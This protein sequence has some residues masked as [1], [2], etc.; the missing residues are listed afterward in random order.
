MP[1]RTTFT[2]C[3]STLPRIKKI[4]PPC[5]C[6]RTI[7]HRT[8]VVHRCK[9]VLRRLGCCGRHHNCTF[10]RVAIR[11][12]DA[13]YPRRLIRLGVIHARSTPLRTSIALGSFTTT[14]HFRLSAGDARP[15]RP[16]S[17]DAD[18]GLHRCAGPLH[19]RR[20][21]AVLHAVQLESL[22]IEAAVCALVALDLRKGQRREGDAEKCIECLRLT[23]RARHVAQARRQ[24]SIHLQ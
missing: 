10:R 5:Q 18:D 15:K 4:N 14:L 21:L 9:D 12:R 16:F 24:I 7:G 11:R 19:G 1:P 22:A 6:R 3:V 2:L 8:V 13:L 20:D 17:L 23:L